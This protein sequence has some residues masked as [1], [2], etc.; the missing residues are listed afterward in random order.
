MR[1]HFNKFSV[2]R[3]NDQEALAKARSLSPFNIQT[4]EKNFQFILRFNDIRSAD[5]RAEDT[6]RDGRHILPRSETFTYKSTLIGESK[7][8]V[9]LTVDGTKTE[10]YLATENEGYFIESARKYSSHARD[11]DKVIYQVRDKVNHDDGVCGLDE[12]IALGIETAK[13]NVNFNSVSSG[14]SG[15]RILKVA[16]EADKEFVLEQVTGNGDPV[17]ANAHILSVMNQVDAVFE[18]QLNIKIVITFQHAWMS[19]TIDPYEGITNSGQMVVAFADYWNNNFPSSNPLYRRN[20]AHLFTQKPTPKVDGYAYGIVCG[21]LVPY[22]FT[23][24]RVFWKWIVTAHELGHNLHAN[25]TDQ[26]PPA[27]PDCVNTIM[28]PPL[29]G[30]INR[31]CSLSITQ[32]TSYLDN[33]GSC[34]E[35]EPSTEVRTLFD[36]DADGEADVSVFRPSNNFWYIQ[37]STNGFYATAFGLPTDKL[38]PADF[39]GDGKTDIA[40][41][42]NGSWYI[43]RSNNGFISIGFGTSEDIPVPGDFTGDGISEL[44]VFRPSNGYWYTYDLTNNQFSGVAFGTSEDKPLSSD[45]DG[46]GKIDYAVFRPSTSEWRIQQSLQGFYSLN[47]GINTDLPVPADYDNDGK[48]DITIFRPSTG[49]WYLQR[50]VLGFQAFPFGNNSDKIVSA[51]YDADNKMDFA[52]YRNG[53]W[54]IQRSRNGFIAVQFGNANDIPQPADYNG[55]QKAEVAVFRPSTGVWHLYNLATNQYLSF[56]FGQAGDVPVAADYDGDLKTDMGGYR[57]GTWYLNRSQDGFAILQ[58]GQSGDKP[59]PANYDG[60]DRK[61]DVAVFRPSNATWYINGSRT[62]FTAVQFGFETDKPVP[63]DYDGDSKADIAVYRN[64]TWYIQRSQLG[65][66]AFEFGNASDLPIAYDSVP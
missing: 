9:A 54:Y 18:Q 61:V 8:V 12:V 5:Y 30:G 1:R 59:I 63:T 15:R 6:D 44:A 16:T 39:D 40:V 66:I 42:R 45:F 52:V 3:I 65:F 36:F 58:F 31:F 51:D 13:S 19:N 48:A 35:F 47:F 26:P 27:P 14:L 38:S 50:S 53:V 32:I 64:G 41:F 2:V 43:Q 17:T 11:D 10:G 60:D 7:S 55:D 23:S 25:H 37:Q 34:L 57:N 46:D 28:Q 33:S 4:N 29:N 24:T 21:S 49:M 22:S 62:G 56:Q 20:V